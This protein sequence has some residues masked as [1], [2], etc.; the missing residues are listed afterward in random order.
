MYKHYFNMDKIKT[1]K[2]LIYTRMIKQIVIYIHP[3]LNY[4]AIKVKKLLLLVTYKWIS[5]T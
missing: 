1:T 4:I 3:M 5:Q 2:G